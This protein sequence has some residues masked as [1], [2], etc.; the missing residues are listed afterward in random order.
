MTFVIKVRIKI[1]FADTGEGIR[2]EDLQ[3]V[4]QPF[5]SKRADGSRGTGLGLTLTKSAVESW[6]GRIAAENTPKSG[7]CFSVW[8]P[9]AD[10]GVE[11]N[12][13]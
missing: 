3:F 12:D 5:W 1:D 7:V 11:Y 9:C 6:G 8:L 13:P 2:P 10:A 4:F